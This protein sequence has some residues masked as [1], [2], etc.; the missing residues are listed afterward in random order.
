MCIS[1]RHDH[2]NVQRKEKIRKKVPPHHHDTFMTYD[3]ICVR[4]YVCV[5]IVYVCT[6]LLLLDPTGL[7]VP[8][9]HHPLVA[10]LNIGIR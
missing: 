9:T 1:C 3:L 4:L 7:L 6:S 8:L 5:C 10:I 2:C